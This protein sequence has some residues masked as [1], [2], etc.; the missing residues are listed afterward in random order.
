MRERERKGERENYFI[1]EILSGHNL[2]I[3]T[4]FI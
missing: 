2:F 3:L 1:E 4:E